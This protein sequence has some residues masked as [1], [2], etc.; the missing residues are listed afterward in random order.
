MN[1]KYKKINKSIKNPEINHTSSQ[2]ECPPPDKMPL[3]K[4]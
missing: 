3:G 2:T 4:P 1:K